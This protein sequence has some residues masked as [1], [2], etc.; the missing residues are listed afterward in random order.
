VRLTRDGGVLACACCGA[1][2]PVA[3]AEGWVDLVPRTSVGE[4]TQYADH[5]FHERLHV[6]EAEPVLSARVKADMMR[7][8]L[9]AVPGETVLDLGCGA[10]KMALYAAQGGRRAAG[11][12]VAPFFLARAARE[13]DLVLGDL[14]RLPFRKGSFP[15][16][17]SLDVLEHLDETGVRE[18]LLEARRTL[19]P[20]GRL[21]VYT[22]AMESSRLA[23][24]QRAVNRLARRLGQAGLIDHER[25]AMRK[26]DHRN[27]IRS[28]EHFDELC[29]AAG[30]QVAERRYYNVVFKAVVEDLGLRL[31]EQWRRRGAK[32]EAPAPHDAHA[33]PAG[34]AT[35]GTSRPS[36][37]LLAV[38]HALTWLLKLDVVLFGG[39]R[40]G[41]FFG[42]LVPR[43]RA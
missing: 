38:A 21:F 37:A 43:E 20:R 35:V 17:Y 8:M 15:R 7:R 9:G 19:G 30:L 36:P 33:H 23:S 27:A 32:P 16:A 29:A 5:E 42:L 41:P 26:S 11:L 31:F 13:V 6:T 2:Y 4:V 34:G 14:R 10:G 12:D 3:A 39:V 24:F 18:V 25:E 28:H 22:H 1:R 40:T